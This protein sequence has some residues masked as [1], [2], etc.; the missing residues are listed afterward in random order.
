MTTVNIQSIAPLT[1]YVFVS[2]VRKCHNFSHTWCTDI[3]FLPLCT[4]NVYIQGHITRTQWRIGAYA[5]GLKTKIAHCNH[6]LASSSP[7]LLKHFFSASVYLPVT[8]QPACCSCQL[9]FFPRPC[10]RLNPVS[11]PS[12]SLP[13]FF[14]PVLFSPIPSI[15]G[16]FCSHITS[17]S[18]PFLCLPFIF[19]PVLAL[20]QC[21]C[22]VHLVLLTSV[23]IPFPCL[24]FSCPTFL[25]CQPLTSLYLTL[26]LLP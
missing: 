1:L 8:P 16:S 12:L 24:C 25:L 6:C 3:F 4:P 13:F 14:C 11:F 21:I 20:L 2:F 17:I 26:H 15:Y 22:M 10:S 5:P 23:S 19:Y 7:R 9:T 18:F